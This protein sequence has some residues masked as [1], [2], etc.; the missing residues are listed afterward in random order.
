MKKRNLLTTFLIGLMMFSC[1]SEEESLFINQQG[2]SF[3]K[4][5]SFR[6]NEIFFDMTVN[7]DGDDVESIIDRKYLPFALRFTRTT[8]V[9]YSGNKVS[10]IRVYAYKDDPNILFDDYLYAVSEETNKIILT[11]E[12]IRIEISYT[13]DYVDSVIQYS[14]STN[15]M[16]TSNYYIRDS[17]DNLL[18]GSLS[19]NAI[20][21]YSNHDSGR[22]VDP[23]G[24]IDT[25]HRHFFT[26]FG[27]K[28][29]ANNPTTYEQRLFGNPGWE[30]HYTYEYDDEDYPIRRIGSNSGN[31]FIH[32]YVD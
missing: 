17:N 19:D 11:S 2:K 8:D 24:I 9:T 3:K 5:E 10:T 4:G 16:L 28:L 18:S 1:S 29:T 12:I 27:L 20:N 15:I 32:S 23:H 7:Y 6:N 21:Y 26:V 31:Y 30:H 13:D 14:V 22:Q 25:G